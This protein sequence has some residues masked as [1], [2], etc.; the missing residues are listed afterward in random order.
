ML[1]QRADGWRLRD[2]GS[3]NGTSVANSRAEGRSTLES[4]TQ[5]VFGEIAFVFVAGGE[6]LAMGATPPAET[7][8]ASRAQALRIILSRPDSTK[9]IVLIAA[10]VTA[11]GQ[12][13]GLAL[14]KESNDGDWSD[15]S[16]TPME[17]ELLH[18]LGQR[19]LAVEDSPSQLSR[20]VAA[21]ELARS[22]PF[23]SRYASDENVRQLV[24]RLRKSLQRIG[25]DDLI[26]TVPGRGYSVTWQTTTTSG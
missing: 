10:P 18:A 22:L 13:T 26:D 11:D 8:D 2:L 20:C 25:V 3:R 7:A 5:I 23:Q 1:E 6:T 19:A 4:V 14:A 21:K 24:R 16:L 12:R 15:L 9:A 17:F